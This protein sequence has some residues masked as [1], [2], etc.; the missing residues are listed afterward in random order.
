MAFKYERRAPA[1]DERLWTTND[2]HRATSDE[3]HVEEVGGSGGSPY[4]IMLD[5][6]IV[7][8]AAATMTIV[9]ENGRYPFS[10]ERAHVPIPQFVMTST[11]YLPSRIDWMV[12]PKRT[13]PQPWSKN[14]PQPFD[15]IS[16]THMEPNNKS[17]WNIT[18]TAYN[19]TTGE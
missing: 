8:A 16:S 14:V 6:V 11:N 3:R 7:I 4:I 13:S 15:P 1:R 12:E 5:I 9:I 2:V 10:F 17:H 18:R 19:S